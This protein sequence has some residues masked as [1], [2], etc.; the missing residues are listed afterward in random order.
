MKYLEILEILSC[1]QSKKSFNEDNLRFVLK[2][3]VLKR[4]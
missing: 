3:I 1:I 2:T 4:C